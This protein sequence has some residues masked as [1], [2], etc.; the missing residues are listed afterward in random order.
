MRRNERGTKKREKE[1]T[2]RGINRENNKQL[3]YTDFTSRLRIS[4]SFRGFVVFSLLHKNPF[5]VLLFEVPHTQKKKNEKKN[6]KKNHDENYESLSF[7]VNRFGLV[8]VA[9][10]NEVKE[11][12]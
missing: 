7:C 2:K 8:F 4:G 12:K 6:E 11:V 1:I 9:E 10:K 3:V 5:Y